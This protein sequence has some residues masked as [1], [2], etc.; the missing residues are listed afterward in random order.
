MIERENN[1]ERTYFYELLDGPFTKEKFGILQ[2]DLN[3]TEKE[4]Y[5]YLKWLQ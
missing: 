5:Q 1:I 2:N 4:V 3:M